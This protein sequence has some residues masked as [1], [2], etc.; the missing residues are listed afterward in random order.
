M[1]I[2]ILSMNDMPGTAT[3][4]CSCFISFSKQLCKVATLIPILQTRK[5]IQRSNLL[6]ITHPLGG[7]AKTCLWYLCPWLVHFLV[8]FSSSQ[9]IRR[10]SFPYWEL[11][12]CYVVLRDLKEPKTYLTL[13][14]TGESSPKMA[15]GQ[16]SFWKVLSSCRKIQE[17]WNIFMPLLLY[18]VRSGWFRFP[19]VVIFR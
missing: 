19:M 12:A 3:L 9:W 11:P 6:R 7:G 5:Q 14:H 15:K 13:N 17:K 4:L 10:T 2:I 18:T 16:V 8:L 1:G